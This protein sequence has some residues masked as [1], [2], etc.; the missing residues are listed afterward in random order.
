[1]RDEEGTASEER[2]KERHRPQTI[3]VNREDGTRRDRESG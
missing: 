2:P 1:M 3:L